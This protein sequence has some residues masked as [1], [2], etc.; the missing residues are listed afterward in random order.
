MSIIGDRIMLVGALS[1]ERTL[2]GPV[3]S[4]NSDGSN[5]S[6]LS[7]DI[8]AQQSGSGNPSPTNVRPIIG[9]DSA[10][11]HVS[12]TQTGGTIYDVSFGSA[13]TVFGGTLNVLTGEL[14]VTRIGKTFLWS[15]GVAEYAPSGN[16]FKRRTFALTQ[17]GVAGATHS[18][19]NCIAQYNTGIPTTV[20]YYYLR[21]NGAYMYAWMPINTD[22]SAEIQVEYDLE[23]PQ[24]YQLTAQQV[25]TLI[26]QNYVWAECGDVTLTYTWRR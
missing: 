3:V 16:A 6:A 24:T 8:T 21:A 9:Y 23:T 25:A 18:R 5:L 19:M 12:P 20:P 26:G 1:G 15:A 11:I 17:T 7:V 22:E 2:S 4:F 10:K 14:T 13:G